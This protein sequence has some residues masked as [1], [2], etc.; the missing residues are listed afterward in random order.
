MR[1]YVG[2]KNSPIDFNGS[3]LD[4]LDREP[5]E[6]RAI[7]RKDNGKFAVAHFS[8]VRFGSGEQWAIWTDDEHAS[9]FKAMMA[10]GLAR[11]NARGWGIADE[12]K[13]VRVT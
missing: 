12:V 13:Y 7:V 2:T 8:Y 6:T 3:V 4:T 11:P 1:T 10:L 9:Q 5:E